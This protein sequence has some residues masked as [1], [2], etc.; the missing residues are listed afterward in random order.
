MTDYYPMPTG[1]QTEG[2]YEIFKYVGV[3][4]TGGYFFPVILLVIWIVSFLALKQYSS[5]KAFTFASLFCSILGIMLAVLD[6]MSPRW[7]YMVVFMTVVGLVW[8]KLEV[9]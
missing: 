1:N 2:L 3:T 8:L 6:L 5:S 4:A 7:M 9:T